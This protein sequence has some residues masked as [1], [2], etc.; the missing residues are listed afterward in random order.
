V[1]VDGNLGLISLV[2]AIIVRSSLSPFFLQ[3]KAL[4]FFTR[5]SILD[6]TLLLLIVG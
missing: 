4:L 2:L 3:P 6:C 5:S 1:P